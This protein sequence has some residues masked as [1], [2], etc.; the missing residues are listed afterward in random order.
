[1]RVSMRNA[2]VVV[3]ALFSALTVCA[4]VKERER[5]KKWE[6][7]VPGARFIDRFMPMEGKRME[8]A[9]WG[10]KAVR[11]RLVDNGIESPLWSYWGG[12]IVKGDDERYHLFV[13]GWRENSAR[14]HMEW[15]RSHVFHA[16]SDS[17]HGPFV[18]IDSIGRGHNPEIYR[19]ADGRY[20]LYVI[21]GRYV[22]KN[23]NG[24]WEYGKFEFDTRGK[25]VSDG[26]S[27][28]SFCRRPDG[29]FMMVTRG[30]EIW[31]S[32]DGLG[33]WRM[34][35]ERVYPK[36]EGRFEDPVI[37]RDSVQYHLIVN[38]WLGRIAYYMR[39]ADGIKWVTDPG[40][41]YT[42]GIARH[43]DGTS[44]EWFKYERIKIFQDE[45]GRAVQANFAVIDTLK[46]LDKASDTHS[47]KN[48]AIPLNPGML[49]TL[50]NDKDSD[51]LEIKIHAE[52]GFNPQ[53]DIDI[54]S[55]RFGAS[56]EVNFGRGAK[57]VASRKA[58]KD[59]IVSFI[60]KDSG[61]TPDEFAPKMLGR[62]KRGALLFGYVKFADGSSAQA[63]MAEAAGETAYD[64]VNPLDLEFHRL[65]VRRFIFSNNIKLSEFVPGEIVAFESM[66]PAF[67]P[68]SVGKDE[69]E[70]DKL[71]KA[72]IENGRLVLDGRIKKTE[73]GKG[74]ADVSLYVGAVNPFGS[75]ELD[76][77]SIDCG[78][79]KND[80]VEVGFELARLG[81]QDRVQLVVRRS[82]ESGGVYL[83]IYQDGK[84]VREKIYTDHIPDGP[85]KL[86]AQLYGHSLGAFI[87]EHGKTT[88]VGYVP[89][90]EN[91][92]ETIDF[93][94]I[95]DCGQA[96]FNIVSNLKGR[97]VVGGACSYL[98][99]GIGQAD[100]R[101]IS[102]EDLSPYMDDNRLWF[103]FSCRGIDIFQS[104][105][106]VLSVDPSVFDVRFE[107]MIMYDHG[108]GLL[109]NDYASHLFFNRQTKEWCAYACDF[110]GTYNKE[111]R[112]GTGL[113][114]G[115]SKRDPRRGFSVMKARRIETTH[116]KHHNED[117]CIFYDKEV[118][119]WRLLTS[120]FQ[121]GIVSGT[122][123]SDTWDGVFTPVA[124]PIKMNSTGTS[125]QRIGGKVYAFMGGLGQLRCHSY[126]DL[127]ELGELNLD[128]QPHWPGP[129]KRV[130]AS[131][132]PLPE[133]YPYRYVLLT[134]DRP[135]FPGTPNPNWSY[136][137]LYF[138]GAN[139]K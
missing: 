36:I 70:C 62:T 83:R 18:V 116:V 80:S 120:V 135:N 12:N 43:K 107:G 1:M 111:G 19:L 92:S 6:R 47:S 46:H 26:Y 41:A 82:A 128:L 40:E 108:D 20:V 75:Y 88:F 33:K 119:K 58:K 115:T 127:K 29:Q 114:I 35:T 32:K 99:P 79:Q 130:W 53:K 118:G 49:L 17:K 21:D 52:K 16:V 68:S 8:N 37:W 56:A 131:L 22:A 69:A 89:V 24:P 104:A 87:E 123:E 4:Q 77:E 97:V 54:E 121:N 63:A 112:S 129:A 124:E 81:L 76:I 30:G 90:K 74:T 134:M 23:L 95:T 15:G 61:I 71:F 10:A 31:T 73:V 14:G 42:P 11:R 102:N 122:F 59:L 137:A 27:N 45:Y 44:E 5:P 13:C 66:H 48:I 101:L 105:Q 51:T 39:S 136:G 100:I 117:P 96:T 25:K 60:R 3:V 38:D 67:V 28:M 109:R 34:L 72:V 110:G 64:N 103:T 50:M 57:V 133:G 94:R 2:F 138:Y 85:F 93:R 125:M 91:F 113:V 126:P 7:L 78:K 86:R 9:P 106:G 132:V 139:I 84:V 65:A 55:L 98:S